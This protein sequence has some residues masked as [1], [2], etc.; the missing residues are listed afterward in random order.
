MAYSEEGRQWLVRSGNLIR[1]NYNYLRDKLKGTMVI[2]SEYEGPYFVVLNFEAYVKF[3]ERWFYLRK[4]PIGQQAF[5]VDAFLK[6]HRIHGTVQPYFSL[7]NVYTEVR[8][9]I[10]V[11]EPYLH[12]F[13]DKLREV[14][15]SVEYEHREL[16]PSL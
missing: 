1:G 14:L 12:A 13:A 2:M 8:F 4:Q 3:I 6:A 15:L 10:G 7:P 5:M 9:T 16:G 11:E